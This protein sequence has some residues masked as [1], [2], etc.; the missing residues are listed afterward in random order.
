MVDKSEKQ[1]L[2]VGGLNSL[3]GRLVLPETVALQL[4]SVDQPWTGSGA[5]AYIFRTGN[6][7]K[8]ILTSIPE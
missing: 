5:K 3:H 2:L 8:N 4:L 6:S 1:I 7:K